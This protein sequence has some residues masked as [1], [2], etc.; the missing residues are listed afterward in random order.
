M[1]ESLLVKMLSSSSLSDNN[2][3]KPES[4]G[5]VLLIEDDV[6]WPEDVLNPPGVLQLV[7]LVSRLKG[8]NGVEVLLGNIIL[9]SIIPGLSRTCLEDMLVSWGR[10]MTI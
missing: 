5:L 9:A 7:S 8:F 3:L 10:L 1:F 2:E 4:K 6:S